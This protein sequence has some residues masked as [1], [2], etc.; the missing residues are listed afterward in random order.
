VIALPPV[1]APPMPSRREAVPMA[2]VSTITSDEMLQQTHQ[3]S[4]AFRAKTPHS[5]MSPGGGAWGH[6]RAATEDD[7]NKFDRRRGTTQ[8]DVSRWGRRR[9]ASEDDSSRPATSP[10]SPKSPTSPTSP[11]LSPKSPASAT[12]TSRRVRA[13]VRRFAP[14]GMNGIEGAQVFSPTVVPLARP[15]NSGDRPDGSIT[16]SAS[17]DMT[18]L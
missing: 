15:A 10:K 17:A 9:L 16:P 6:R 14:G 8:D 7:V 5:P 18:T 3:Y 1:L 11:P 12:S 13:G 2:I 4:N